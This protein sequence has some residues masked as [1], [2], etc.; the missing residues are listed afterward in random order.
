ML[1]MYEINAVILLED[2]VIVKSVNSVSGRTAR[3]EGFTLIELLIVIAIIGMLASIAIPML[4]GQ[5]DRAK[6]TAITSTAKSIAT[7]LSTLLDDYESRQPAVF[8]A[9]NNTI[10]CYEFDQAA[11]WQR[12]LAR[13]PDAEVID[14]YSNL[15]DL[16]D[17]FLSH[18]NSS[19]A[20]TSPFTG[21]P[22]LTRVA[23]TSG[24]VNLINTTER[25]IY[26]IVNSASGGE[27]FNMMV[28]SR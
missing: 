24:H 11:G 28:T 3:Q 20:E 16:L 5:R 8:R 15:D 6:I 19:L 7:E 23:G 27:I 25:T 21:A 14:T 1:G 9:T 2:V 26:V 10:E 22:L 12:C 18:H 13:Y 4:L 17:K